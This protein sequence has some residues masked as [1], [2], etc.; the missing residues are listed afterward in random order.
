[1]ISW[2]KAAGGAGWGLWAAV[3][4]DATGG[5][6]DTEATGSRDGPRGSSSAVQGFSQS[7]KRYIRLLPKPAEVQPP[8]AVLACC[9]PD[10]V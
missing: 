7:N 6:N 10:V 5:G 2:G 9:S 3:S 1:M 8:S 4:P